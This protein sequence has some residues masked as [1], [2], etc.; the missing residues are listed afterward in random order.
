MIFQGE[1][2]RLLSRDP[3]IGW[4]KQIV[5]GFLAAG[6]IRLIRTRDVAKFHVDLIQGVQFLILTLC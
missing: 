5:S 4:Q 3:N 2:E 6:S 1:E